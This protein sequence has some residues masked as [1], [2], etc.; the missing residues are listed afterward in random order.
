MD[1][2]SLST[3]GKLAPSG[4]GRDLFLDGN[5][6]VVP[7]LS[8]ETPLAVGAPGSVDGL[9]R[10]H[11]DHGSGSIGRAQ[12]LAPA[13]RLARDGV[14]L[15]EDL[16]VRL[17]GARDYLSRDDAARALFVR[18]DGRDWIPG[19]RLVQSDLAEALERVAQEG[20]DGFYRA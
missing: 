13:I 10:L 1:A 8:L 15:G 3:S 7:G 2:T 6:D 18:S 12:L 16:A 14:V 9:L 19:D 4:A 5:G 17:N 11:E 20:R